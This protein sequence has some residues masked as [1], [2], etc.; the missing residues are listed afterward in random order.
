MSIG[1]SVIAA[2]ALP[3]RLALRGVHRL[4]TGRHAVLDVEI[5][6][7]DEIL[8][9]ER[10]RRGLV[11]AAEDP[12]VVAVLLRLRGAPGGWAACQDLRAAIAGLRARGRQVYAFLETPGNAVMAVAAACDRI[13]AV[14]TGEVGLVGVGVELTFFGRALE[15]LGV[16]PDFEA[17]GAY[18]SF[19]EPFTRSFPSP[20][21]QEATGELVEDLQDQLVAAIATGRGRPVEGVRAM[22][23]RAPL[24]AE[25]ARELGLVD[26]LVYEDQLEAWLEARHGASTRLRPFEA[27]SRRA[28]WIERLG[29]IGRVDGQVAVLHLEGAIAL[30]PGARAL[31]ARSVVPILRALR[32]DD[33]VAAVVLHVDS[34]GGS[35]LASDLM[36]REVDLLAR[37][38]VVLASFADVAA[39]GGFY[40]AAPAKEIYVR[41]GTLTGSIGV[42]GGKLV[43]ADGL[44]QAGVH[45]HPVVAAP[46]AVAFS[47]SRPFTDEQRARFRS[48]L[49]RFY[50]GFVQ[51]VAAG[52]G[53]SVEA[54]E[55]HCRGRVWTG[56][57]A[58]ERGLADRIGGLDDAVARARELAQARGRRVDLTGRPEPPW[59]RLL[60]AAAQRYVPGAA[61]RA[62]A[63]LAS[64]ALE[65]V[66]THEGEPLAL[67]PITFDPR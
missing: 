39:S 1:S 43:L 36:W 44:R 51:R 14:P 26:E 9:R 7:G 61:R 48:S 21:N 19:G 33:A 25:E 20:A 59:A 54:V 15:R 64:P 58:V 10:L 27:W 5:E 24:S 52:R 53:R 22:I 17:A 30:E 66:W 32:E 46:N 8:A 47:A 6:Q 65:V 38:K 55:P 11:L 12:G 37:K 45:T 31:S 62:V 60:R 28:R 56:R 40:L 67:L 34:P 49:Q 50:D 41:A 29:A 4:A 35:A 16:T 18:K 13:L 57:M 2:L 63:A 42:F 3:P 23:A